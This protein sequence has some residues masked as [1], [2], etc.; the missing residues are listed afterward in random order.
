MES[1]VNEFKEIKMSQ[2]DIFGN[3]TKES[4]V[5]KKE[6]NT[7]IHWSFSKMQTFR[8]CPRRYYFLYYGSKKRTAK[9]EPLKNKLSTLA[10]LS[11]KYLY[12]GYLIH[13]LISIYF[14]K[15]KSGD[16]WTLTKLQSF[17]KKIIE[18]VFV[19]NDEVKSG[20]ENKEEEYPKPLL[21]E[22]LYDKVDPEE[23]KEEIFETVSLCL[24][25]FLTAKQYKYIRKGGM[26]LS[27]KIEANT[28]F[29]LK[30]NLLIDGKVDIAFIDEKH[31]VIADWKTGKKEIEDTSLQLLVYA[32]WARQLKDWDFGSLEIQKAYLADGIVETMEFSELHVDRAK[33]RIMQDVE[34]L[35]EMDEFG[36][37]SIKDAFAMHVG[38]NCKNCQFEEI[39]NSNT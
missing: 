10:G 32:I 27:S 34:L 11:N 30:E 33:A 13:N 39:C 19:Y 3:Q 12:Q 20:S 21:K 2:I 8:D 36:K 15:A 9:E 17:A 7:K 25:S 1:A 6:E 26:K 24:E 35:K 14:K 37:A 5:L 4:V 16:T 28:S 29:I 31:L 38:D 23:L 18:E 22:L